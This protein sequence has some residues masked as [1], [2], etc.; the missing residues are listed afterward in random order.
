MHVTNAQGAPVA[1]YDGEPV[2]D[3]RPT[4][5]WQVHELIDERIGIWLPANIPAGQYQVTMGLYDPDSGERLPALGAD[6][7]RYP[8]D[9]LRVGSIAV[10]G[11]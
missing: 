11:R 4:N 10:A 9:A 6:G 8:D 3:L 2:A 5:S 1:Q 7:A